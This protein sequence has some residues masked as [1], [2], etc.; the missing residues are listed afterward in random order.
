VNLS[1]S[2]TAIRST[3][4]SAARRSSSTPV[5]IELALVGFLS[6]VV[7]VGLYTFA[8]ERAGIFKDD[9]RQYG[10]M[11]EDPSFLTRLPYSFRVLTPL[12]ASAIPGDLLTGFVIVTLAGLL[13]T[14][15][16]LYLFLRA[17][18]LGP[19]VSLA[20]VALFLG[21]GATTRALTT[22]VYVDALTYLAEVA[23]FYCLLVRREALF[24]ATLVFGVLNRETILLLVPLYLLQLR[25]EG[26]LTR[27]HL[28]RIALVV[29]LP[30]LTLGLVVVTKLL[31]A[32]ALPDGLGVLEPRARTFRQTIP[33]WPE[34]ADIYS[35]YG[36]AWL[37]A[38]LNLRRAPPFLR[39]G[40]LF[41]VL[42]VL[43]LSV[44]RGDE[45]RNLS[46]LLPLVI[47][48][49]VLE[50]RALSPARGLALLVACLASMLNFRWVLV[51]ITLVRYALVALGS[52]VAL[53]LAAWGRVVPR[54]SRFGPV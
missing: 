33:T 18:D 54:P 6:L 30:L 15:M 9:T 52:L 38:I 32:G 48:L 47:P 39:R 25:S 28:P 13:A 24:A 49:A 29:G 26:R 3:A 20:G 36:A 4:S 16:V 11:A 14:S 31:A 34:L 43:Q 51:P 8:T 50:F 19:W 46:H 12:L 23:A 5:T 45:G 22:P 41:G 7:L 44:S 37:L 1:L 21:S 10:L 17:L 27:A 35:V 40:L 42:V 2:P 53:A